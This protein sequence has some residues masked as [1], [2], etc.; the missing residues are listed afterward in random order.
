M[1]GRSHAVSECNGV[2]RSSKSARAR[3]E[4][5]MAIEWMRR[6]REAGVPQAQAEAIASMPE[7]RLV[8]KDYLDARLDALQKE[9]TDTLTVRMLGV[10]TLV[11][12]LVGL[13]DKVVRP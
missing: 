10:A 9:L 4:L 7:E 1:R 6:M 11:I 13:V 2:L 3:K 8:T 5:L 12:V